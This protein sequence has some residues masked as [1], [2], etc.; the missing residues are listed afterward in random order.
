MTSAS[1]ALGSLSAG[2]YGTLVITVDPF[3]EARTFD[4]IFALRR[5]GNAA[6]IVC[7]APSRGL[8]STTRSKGLR[9]GADDFS[10][11]DLPPA[12]LVERIHM[13]WM[14]G[15]HRR[16]GPSQIGQILQ[17]LN[18]DGS[19]RPMTRTEFL[20]AMGTLVAEQ[21]PLFFCY[22]EFSLQA[23]AASQ[24]WP[25]L[26]GNVRIGDGYI[27][28]ALTERRFACALDRITPEQT[29]RVIERIRAAHPALGGLGDVLV[30]PSPGATD[31]I[32]ERLA[33]WSA[34]TLDDGHSRAFP[35]I[36]LGPQSVPGAT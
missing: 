12:E 33:E 31:R 10:V 16:T 3:D 21:P 11:A 1:G 17:P 20:Q 36:S 26:R 30:I 8:R 23:G 2:R 9:I 19:M 28:G 24:V 7:V 25:S 5:E 34:P 6:P 14:R 15:T 27:V 32:R 35:H 22:L 18:G 13:A 4:L 29:Q